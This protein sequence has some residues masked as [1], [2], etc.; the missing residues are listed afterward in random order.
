METAHQKNINFVNVSVPL[1]RQS[2]LMLIKNIE[3]QNAWNVLHTR[4]HHNVHE[5]FDWMGE[6]YTLVHALR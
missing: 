4:N 6:F 2:F 3:W 5:M 1:E